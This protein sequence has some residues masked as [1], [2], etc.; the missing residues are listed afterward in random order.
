MAKKTGT[1]QVR[2]YKGIPA[3]YKGI[4]IDVWQSNIRTSI[5][6][7]DAPSGHY[8]AYSK[9]L[10]LE[11]IKE[12]I[13][14]DLAALE[15]NG[16]KNALW[17]GLKEVRVK[18]DRIIDLLKEGTTQDRVLSELHE[19]KDDLDDLLKLESKVR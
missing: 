1:E 15:R 14:R 2:R 13:D 18:V 3:S 12:V 6:I 17:A 10:A 16:F 4:P 5:W 19:V 7:A 9:K 8:M 11:G